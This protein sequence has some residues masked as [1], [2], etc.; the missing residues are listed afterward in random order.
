MDTI[1]ENNNTG[2]REPPISHLSAVINRVFISF[3]V[4]PVIGSLVRNIHVFLFAVRKHAGTHIN[5]HGIRG[6]MFR[7]N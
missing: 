2:F 6:T 1:A 4:V 3:A 7:V 5:T